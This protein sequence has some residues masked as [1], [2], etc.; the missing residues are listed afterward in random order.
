MSVGLDL[1]P[2][3]AIDGPSGK[4]RAELGIDRSTALVGSVGRLVPV[5]DHLTLIKA[6]RHLQG[7][8]LAIV[9]DGD[10]RPR[11]EAEAARFGLLS[12]VHFL[13]WRNDLA[14]LYSD[15]DVVALTSLNEGTPVAM[16]EALASRRPVVA[17]AVGG[18]THVIDDGRTGMLASARDHHAIAARIEMLL[19]DHQA[20]ETL[21]SAGRLEVA[22]RFGQGR[23][24]DETR[25]LYRSLLTTRGRWGS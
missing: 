5:K 7:T 4:L 20:A 22:A 21:A 1:S 12:R 18:V 15:M 14:E 13:G 3:L 2:Y 19:K 9:G 17:T 24:V 23:L 25:D 11:L 16:I 10:L 8:H 6:I